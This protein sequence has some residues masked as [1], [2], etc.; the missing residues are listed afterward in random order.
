MKLITQ[1]FESLIGFLKK[2][3][4]FEIKQHYVQKT[5]QSK[6][7]TVQTFRGQDGNNKFRNISKTL[8]ENRIM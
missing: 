3:T 1:T 8:V 4:C 5:K 7:K 6:N 2:I